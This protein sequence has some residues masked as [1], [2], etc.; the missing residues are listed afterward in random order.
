MKLSPKKWI[1][2]SICVYHL[3]YFIH[4]GRHERLTPDGN[5]NIQ[6]PW[7]NSSHFLIHATDCTVPHWCFPS[8]ATLQHITILQEQVNPV[9]WSH[10]DEI[11]TLE[12]M[13][14]IWSNCALWLFHVW[15]APIQ[16][17]DIWDK[18]LDGHSAEKRTD[19]KRPAATLR[20]LLLWSCLE[21]WLF[22]VWIIHDALKKILKFIY[23]IFKLVLWRLRYL[24]SNWILCTMQV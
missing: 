21:G 4:P 11:N 24:R 6:R 16:R 2:F 13:K 17:K 22:Y 15:H 1:F 9:D 7:H 3:C 23:L 10:Y 18:K 19:T 14:L 12:T 20:V 5:L 8:I